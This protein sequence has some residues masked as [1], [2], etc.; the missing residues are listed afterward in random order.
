MFPLATRSVHIQ[1]TRFGKEDATELEPS[2]P[3]HFSCARNRSKTE[4]F[5]YS[6]WR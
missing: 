3:V 6:W 1:F 5:T 4:I 2:A